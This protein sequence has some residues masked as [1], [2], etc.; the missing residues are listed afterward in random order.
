MAPRSRPGGLSDSA[1]KQCALLVRC[2]FLIEKSANPSK[3][4]SIQRRADATGIGLSIGGSDVA[5]A[6]CGGASP[7]CSLRA[8]IS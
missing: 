5:R 7:V 4:S 1:R 3:N 8:R 6:P 2:P